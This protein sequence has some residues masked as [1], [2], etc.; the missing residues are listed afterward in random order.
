MKGKVSAFII[1]KN[2]EKLIR[3]A[4]SSLKSIAEEIIVVDSGSTDKTIEIAQSLGCKV[5]YNEWRGYVEQKIFGEGL[6]KNDWVLNID[7]DEELSQDLQNEI[8]YIFESG[9]QDKYKG[10][11]FNIVIMMPEELKPR[12]CAPSNQGI[13]LYNKNYVSFEN[14]DQATRTHDVASLKNGLMPEGNIL[15]LL[16][17]VYHK[18]S[19][20]ISQLMNKISFYTSEQAQEIF[21]KNRKISKIRIALEFVWWF[22]KAYFARRYFV[23]GFKGFIYSVIFAFGKF[24]RL[25]K[26]YE[27][28]NLNKNI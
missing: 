9:L 16:S 21:E 1:A 10:Y 23:F 13:R 11:S 15:K 14:S 22:F 27:L 8:N 26:V 28:Q 2:E 4:I 5:V 18:S 25:A 17:P 12:F 24:L 19:V 3:N 20:S 6:C 7:A